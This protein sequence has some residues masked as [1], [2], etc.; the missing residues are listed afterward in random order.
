[1]TKSFKLLN[2][3]KQ[4]TLVAA[5]FILNLT[6]EVSAMNKAELIDAI[7]S[8][9][10]ISPEKAALIY[11]GTVKELIAA[12]KEGGVDFQPFGII[13]KE[14][15]REAFYG[16]VTVLKGADYD[17]EVFNAKVTLTKPPAGSF[18][19]DSFFD[20]EM[21]VVNDSDI[22]PTESLQQIT[23]IEAKRQRNSPRKRAKKTKE[24][25]G[26][27]TLLRSTG[28]GDLS[29]VGTGEKKEFIGHVTLLRVQAG[30]RGRD[31]GWDGTYKGRMALLS[32]TMS[33]YNFHGHV[34]VLKA[35]LIDSFF[36]IY[37]RDLIDLTLRKFKL[38]IQGCDTK[39][40]EIRSLSAANNFNVDAFFGIDYRISSDEFE[41]EAELALT[42]KKRVDKA[43]PALLSAMNCD[44]IDNDCDGRWS[45]VETVLKEAAQDIPDESICFLPDGTPIRA[46]VSLSQA[47]LEIWGAGVEG[48]VAKARE[49]QGNQPPPVV[50]SSWGM[51][52]ERVSQ[53]TGFDTEMVALSLK[54]MGEAGAGALAKGDK[55]SLAGFGTFS[56]SK[57]A[58]R[59]GRNP[60]TGASI[61]IKAKKVV[62]FKA[63]A[64]LSNAV[65]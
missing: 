40:A 49:I 13:S 43:T 61:Q 45:K 4:I 16:H 15:A 31:R 5:F 46:K 20:I 36:D 62:R 52:L 8:G 65:N 51:I 1:M 50:M 60:Q 33:G 14:E 56:I 17:T 26:H 42:Y 55:V 35:V 64:A 38:D 23:L 34:T 30:R 18:N 29:S 41:K 12:A 58:A 3:C 27:V 24:Y 48:F 2:L 9:A 47:D 7:A 54:S 28:S 44:G 19:V 6:G 22:P 39:G 59:T 25:V 37:F 10:K 57:R 21:S 11:D 32:S 63:G 53:A